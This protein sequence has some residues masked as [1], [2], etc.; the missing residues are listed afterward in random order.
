MTGVP[1]AEAFGDF[2][3][4]GPGDCARDLL[5]RVEAAAGEADGRR[6][7]R[8]DRTAENAPRRTGDDQGG[9]EIGDRQQP[10]E[11]QRRDKPP[12]GAG[13][14][15]RCKASVDRLPPELTTRGAADL[16][17]AAGAQPRTARGRRQR[18]AAAEAPGRREQP[19]GARE[20]WGDPVAEGHLCRLAADQMSIARGK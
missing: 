20:K 4:R 10:A 17:L 11:L 3:T 1:P 19:D 13:V 15:E 14:I 2:G 12:P 9:G 8:H 16:G 7:N 6:R 5:R 18:R